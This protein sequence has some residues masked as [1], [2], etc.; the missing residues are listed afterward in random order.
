MDSKVAKYEAFLEERLKVD[1]EAVLA[2]RDKIYEEVAELLQLRNTIELIQNQKL[3]ELKT[4]VDLGA[5]FSVQAKVT[6]TSR[7]LVSVGFGF[8]TE[9]TLDEAL[10]FVQKKSDFLETKAQA[11]TEDAAKIK[12]NIKLVLEALRELQFSKG[13]S[14][15]PL[16][17]VF[18]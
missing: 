11:L 16:Y 2:Q 14:K 12:A 1:L 18:A 9:F 13:K 7:I 5:N 6:D 15:T 10:A 8:Y 17:D 4:M 3:K